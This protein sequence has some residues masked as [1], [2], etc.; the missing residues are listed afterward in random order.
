MSRRDICGERLEEFTKVGCEDTHLGIT[1]STVF[2]S[3]RGRKT[4]VCG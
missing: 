1:L 4:K 2:T 3:Q